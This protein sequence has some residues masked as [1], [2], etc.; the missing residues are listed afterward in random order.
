MSIRSELETILINWCQSQSP[1]IKIALENVPFIKPPATE[2][3]LEVYFLT[4][5]TVAPDV[6]ATRER[7]RGV[8]QIN[9]CSPQSIGSSKSDEVAQFI[10]QLY[11]IVPKSGTVSIEKPINVMQGMARIDGTWVVGLRI[12]YRQERIV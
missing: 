7:E 5:A 4:S 3:Y 11:P 2:V 1:P 10:K 6:A 8:M 9:I 12:T